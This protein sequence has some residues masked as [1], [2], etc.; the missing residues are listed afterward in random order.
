MLI[1][2]KQVFKQAIREMEE[3]TEIL[4]IFNRYKNIFEDFVNG[5]DI[6]PPNMARPINKKCTILCP[7]L[8]LL[9]I[10][11]N[12][13]KIFWTGHNS[14]NSIMKYLQLEVLLGNNSI[15]LK[16]LILKR[17]EKCKKGG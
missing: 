16:S 17:M 3:K 5:L 12:Q 13:I 14:K 10:G 7:I 9:Q 1:L 2:E 6:Q 8:K 11:P 4:I 15:I